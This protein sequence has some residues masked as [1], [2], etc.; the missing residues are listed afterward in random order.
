ME[1]QAVDERIAEA[2]A[3]HPKFVTIANAADFIEK[4]RAALEV[5]KG[6]LPAC[7]L[8]HQLP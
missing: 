1:A 6:E 8:R 4:A 7:C 5:V 2:W 3:G